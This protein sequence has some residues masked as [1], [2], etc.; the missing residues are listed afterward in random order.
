MLRIGAGEDE[1]AEQECS[2]CF[3][4]STVIGTESIGIAVLDE[5]RC[6]RGERRARAWIVGRK[7]SSDGGQEQRGVNTRVARSALPAAGGVESDRTCLGDDAISER[8][9]LHHRLATSRVGA[10]RP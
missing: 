5:F 10:D 7:R 2:L 9:P 3:A 6:E 8:K 1:A 4:Q